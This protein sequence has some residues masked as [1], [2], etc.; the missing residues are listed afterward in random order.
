MKLA[1]VGG[2]NVATALISRVTAPPSPE[3]AERYTLELGDLVARERPWALTYIGLVLYTALILG[4][5]YAFNT[6]AR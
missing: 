6:L 3:Q 4:V 2:G 1:F 5:C